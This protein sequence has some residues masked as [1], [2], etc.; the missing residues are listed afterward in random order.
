MHASFMRFIPSNHGGKLVLHCLYLLIHMLKPCSIELMMAL[1]LSC[2]I[3]KFVNHNLFKLG[4]SKTWFN[5]FSLSSII[6]RNLISSLYNFFS[7]IFC[8]RLTH[9]LSI[10]DLSQANLV[11]ICFRDFIA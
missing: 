5:F 8:I 9:P 2:E 10:V 1:L 7:Y 4:I 11:Y 6:P 3:V